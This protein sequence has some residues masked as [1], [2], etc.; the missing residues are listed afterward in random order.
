MVFMIRSGFHAEKVLLC[1]L[2]HFETCLTL[3]SIL[4]VGLY[5]DFYLLSI[6]RLAVVANTNYAVV[7]PRKFLMDEIFKPVELYCF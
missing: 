2:S 7:I 1:F 5:K 6:A 4:L 3:P